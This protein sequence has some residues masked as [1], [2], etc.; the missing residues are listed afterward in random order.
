MISAEM[1]RHN[2]PVHQ[3]K[4]DGDTLIVKVAI[5][6]AKRVHT[7]VVVVAQDTD[8]LVLLTYHR[9][10]DCTNLY[11]QS[12]KDGLYDISTI[13]IANREEFLFSYAWSGNDTVSCIH[14]H[15]KVA[16]YKCKFPASIITTFLDSTTSRSD[17]RD[18]GVKAMQITYGCGNT[19]LGKTRFLKFQKQAAKGKIDPDRLPPTEDATTQHSLR[20]HLQVAVWHSLDTSVLD[21]IGRGWETQSDNKLRTKMLSGDIAPPNLLKGICCNC[22]EGDKQC[23]SMKCSCIKSRMTCVAACGVCSGHCSNG[24]EKSD[25][26]LSSDEDDTN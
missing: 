17:I 10:N 6:L 12:E 4:D 16:L 19:S 24:G 21:P 5:D 13:I 3:A 22:Q 2:I 26:E 15:T 7:P 25:A 11:M 23:Q 20:V 9:P 14:G 18:A 1:A 8:I